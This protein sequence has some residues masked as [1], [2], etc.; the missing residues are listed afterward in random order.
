MLSKEVKAEC[1]RLRL[2]EHL[3]LRDIAKRSGVSQA[4]LSVLLRDHPLPPDVLK[5]RK[6]A[7]SRKLGQWN[8]SRKKPKPENPKICQGSS[9]TV[10]ISGYS[11]LDIGRLSEAAILFRLTLHRFHVLKPFFEGDVA[12]CLVRNDTGKCFRIQVKTVLHRAGS[13]SVSLR[14]SYSSKRYEEGEFD[15]I[16]GYNPSEDAAYVWSADEVKHLSATVSICPSARE[17]W[18]KIRSVV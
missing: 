12:D 7:N 5:E 8:T 9:F 16:V 14:K 1:L 10:D 15:F 6:D 13:Q 17:A 4:T 2:E 18:H 3:S 11:T